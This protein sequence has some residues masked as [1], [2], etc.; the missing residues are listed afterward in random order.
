M[1]TIFVLALVVAA[2]FLAHNYLQTGEIGFST[3]LS[4]TEREIRKLDERL[5]DAMRAYRVAGRGAS[6]GG[7][8]DGSSAESALGDVRAVDRELEHLKPRVNEGRE[9][10]RLRALEQKLREAKRLMGV[11]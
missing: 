10:E 6:I 2:I 3:S 11:R 7:L 4:D 9:K 1:K 8:E 5:S